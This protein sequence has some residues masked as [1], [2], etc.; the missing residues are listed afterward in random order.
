MSFIVAVYNI[1]C[2][3][4]PAF[5]LRPLESAVLEE[6][7]FRF[8][9][10]QLRQRTAFQQPALLANLCYTETRRNICGDL[11][12]LAISCRVQKPSSLPQ[13]AP[14]LI[15][16]TSS[17]ARA[18]IATCE[19]VCFFV[20]LADE[21]CSGR[22]EWWEH[23]SAKLDPGNGAHRIL[24]IMGLH[25]PGEYVFMCFALSLMRHS[26]IVAPSHLSLLRVWDPNVEGLLAA[27]ANAQICTFDNRGCGYRYEE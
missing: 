12:T 17:E 14:S 10:T 11:R 6:L 4:T 26:I 3:A 18:I 27:D 13:M 19:C 22:W 21:A 25:A 2:M 1:L 16:T 20:C 9:W 15:C 24:L 8:F 5:H 7:D 23:Q